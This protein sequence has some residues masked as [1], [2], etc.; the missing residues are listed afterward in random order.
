MLM[1]ISFDRK[2]RFSKVVVDTIIGLVIISDCIYECDSGW[3][4]VPRQPPL[5]AAVQKWS[6]SHHAITKCK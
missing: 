2:Y 5:Q 1:T 3:K 4:W 6:Q